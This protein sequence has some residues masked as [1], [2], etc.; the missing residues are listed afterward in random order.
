MHDK[1]KICTRFRTGAVKGRSLDELIGLCK[2]V[3][4]DGSVCQSEAQFLLNWLENNS[5]I[6]DTFPANVIYPR[7]VAML[8]DGTLDDEEAQELLDF[9]KSCTGEIGQEGTMNLSCGIAYNDPLPELVFENQEFC[10]TGQFAYGQRSDVTERTQALGA[11]VIGSVVKRGCILVVGCMATKTWLHS[12][13][14]LKIQKAIE[15]RDAGAP[16]CII[17]EEYWHKQAERLEN[18]I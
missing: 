12:S 14:G 1:E 7:L 2:G 10:L 15:A 5:N 4:A 16:I 18:Y 9:L 17:P 8:A 13:H 11:K 3:I 6:A